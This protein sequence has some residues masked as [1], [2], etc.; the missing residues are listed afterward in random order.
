MKLLKSIHGYKIVQSDCVSIVYL[1]F[2]ELCKLGD[3]IEEEKE[4]ESQ[5]ILKEVYE[6]NS[7]E[8]VAK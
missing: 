6:K 7:I 3:R 4:L 8:K 1:D 5:N 2:E